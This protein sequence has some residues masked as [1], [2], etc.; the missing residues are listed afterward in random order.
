MASTIY[1]GRLARC[2]GVLSLGIADLLHP[3]IPTCPPKAEVQYTVAFTGASGRK[4]GLEKVEVD[5]SGAEG[6]ASGRMKSGEGED[7]ID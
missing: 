4:L 2:R 6:N 5:G 3:R 1:T 7:Y